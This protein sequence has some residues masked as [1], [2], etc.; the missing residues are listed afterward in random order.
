[1][2][3]QERGEQQKA[4]PPREQQTSQLD[5]AYAQAL[6][7]IEQDSVKMGDVPKGPEVQ[8]KHARELA[9][10]NAIIERE[11]TESPE[12]DRDYKY[13]RVLEAIVHDAVSRAQV[14]GKETASIP[15]SEYDDKINGVD[16]L[17]E[18][19]RAHGTYE[20]LALA[21]D[22]THGAGSGM[23]SKFNDLRRR[24]N[25][26]M[27]TR[28]DYLKSDQN[29]EKKELDSVPRVIV[30]MDRKHLDELIGT[31]LNADYE[32]IEKHPGFTMILQQAAGELE[33]FGVVNQQTLT[34]MKREVHVR[35]EQK[36][37]VERSL[38]AQSRAKEII[39]AILKARVTK[40]SVKEQRDYRAFKSSDQVDKAIQA[41]SRELFQGR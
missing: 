17:K 15:A 4:T 5:L 37:R 28:I 30:G 39:N 10:K 2:A 31:W 22:T 23:T 32:A 38:E 11:R 13:G 20:Y 35:P 41:E 19:K 1:M 26:G 18:F 14:F 29:P 3:E 40:M 16:E 33:I 36:E 8:H 24:K 21:I 9:N 12:K 7:L 27:T 34:K 6:G 25:E